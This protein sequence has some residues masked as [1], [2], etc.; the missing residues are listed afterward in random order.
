[1]LSATEGKRG[2]VRAAALLAAARLASTQGDYA[3]QARYDDE[4]RHLFQELGDAAGVAAAVNGLGGAHW[5]TGS[6]DV[7]EANL[8]GGL[9]LFR[10][11]E[12]V[13]GIGLQARPG[14]MAPDSLRIGVSA[15]LLPLACVARDR[16]DLAAARPLF[17]EVLARRR[18]AGDQAGTAHAL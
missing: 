11:L 2:A 3:A 12:D 4:S 16:G 15:A 6:L 5:Q 14:G 17:A 8:V 1:L 9:R 10:A 7:A 13:R 18:A